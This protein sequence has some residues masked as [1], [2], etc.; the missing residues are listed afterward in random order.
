MLRMTYSLMWSLS[1]MVVDPESSSA[2][3][4]MVYAGY[5]RRK[6]WRCVIIFSRVF[7]KKKFKNNLKSDFLKI[8]VKTLRRST[9]SI[10]EMWPFPPSF[11]MY[12]PGCCC[13]LTGC[14]WRHLIIQVPVEAATVKGKQVCITLAWLVLCVSNIPSDCLSLILSI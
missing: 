3:K 1:F 10:E 13:G 2:P 6:V 12:V 9:V 14:L 4:I 11:G 5:L 7:N 8:L